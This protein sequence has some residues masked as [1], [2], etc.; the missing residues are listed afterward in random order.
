MKRHRFQGRAKPGRRAG[1]LVLLSLALFAAL[2]SMPNAGLSQESR[3]SPAPVPAARP[4]NTGISSASSQA[5]PLQTAPNATRISYTRLIAVLCSGLLI[6]AARLARKFR[7]YRGLG[8]FTNPY[9]ILFLI[10]GIG[11]CGIPVTSEGTLKALP[12]LGSLG[13]WI[14]DLSG[15]AV[16]L[17]LPAIRFKPRTQPAGDNQMRDLAGGSSSNPIL[18]V[19]EDA[20]S[21]C[22]LRRMQKEVVEACRRYDWGAIRLAAGRALEEEMTI[23]PLPDEKYNA[24]RQSIENFQPDPDPHAD[25]EK[26]YKA[27]FG[28]LRWCSFHRLRSSLDA[29]A[30][31]IE[32]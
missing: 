6:S 22:I 25:S 23:R 2:V 32:R 16:A 8:V 26:K 9:A 1:L 14:A 29:A 4:A 13:P 15:I 28:L 27:L 5:A 12:F 11:L 21:E 24:V 17:V 10:F 18:A 30:R 7:L 20:I 31:E 3:G 19:I